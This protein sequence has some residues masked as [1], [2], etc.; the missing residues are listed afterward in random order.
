MDHDKAK[1]TFQ[2]HG[3]SVRVPVGVTVREAASLAGIPLEYP[4][5][6]QGTCGKCRVKMAG[7]NGQPGPADKAVFSEAELRAGFR[8]AC[9]TRVKADASIEIPETGL[10]MGKNQILA[11]RSAMASVAADP[12]VR[13][14]FVKMP[15]PTL[16]DDRPDAE[17]LLDAAHAESIVPALLYDLPCLLRDNNFQG[18]AVVSAGCVLDFV[19]G[20]EEAPC[21]AAAFD[22]GTTTLV[23]ELL[24]LHNG[25]VR[26]FA[27]RMNPQSAFGDDVLSRIT[28]ASQSAEALQEV[29]E[30]VLTALNEMLGEMADQAGV[31]TTFIYEVSVS[32][33]TTMEHLFAGLNP[34]ALGQVPF[35]PVSRRGLTL[36]PQQVGID[37]NP[38]GRVY[39]LPV[40]GGFVGGDT[41][42]GIETTRLEE[43]ESPAMLIDIGTNGELALVHHGKLAATSCAAGPAFEGARI[44]CGMRAAAGAVE[45]VVLKDTVKITTV[46]GGAA[47]GLCGSG[48]IDLAAELLRKGILTSQGLFAAPDA[49]PESLPAAL[50]ERVVEEDA[51]AA[52]VFAREEETQ[53]GRPLL[54]TQRDVRELQLATGAI[55]AGI[56][57]LLKRAGLEVAQ[58]SRVYVAGGFGNYIRLANAQRIGLLPQALRE[59]QFSFVGNTSLE[60][61]RASA[62]SLGARARAEAISRATGH[63]DLSCDME[64]QAEFAMAMFFPEILDEKT[65]Q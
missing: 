36:E 57:I 13:T 17:R 40:I 34:H 16:T 2:P 38:R 45:A 48:L 33:N 32:G 46:G 65:V 56:S 52:F 62:L 37:I 24:D 18:T 26:A 12:P 30:T 63:F 59:D 61:A 22:I 43:S 20:T 29:H 58:L 35:V 3:K 41:V 44:S 14:T 28:H 23:G 5:G 60:G 8:L 49:L 11:G 55:R 39:V 54:L 6:G 19:G 15:A 9:Q 21:L 25:A 51:G 42:A 53:S 10:P 64:F 31:K 50:R 7:A 1:I 47:V 27:S 4:C